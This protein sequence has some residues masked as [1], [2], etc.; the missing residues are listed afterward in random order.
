[1]REISEGRVTASR[2][3]EAQPGL[4]DDVVELGQ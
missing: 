2:A 4:L 1:V 3:L